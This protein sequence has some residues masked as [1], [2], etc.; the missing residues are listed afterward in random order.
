MIDLYS[1]PTFN[2]QKIHIALEE[3][4]LPYAAHPVNI[5]KGE[6]FDPAFLRISPNNRIPA[7]VDTDGAGGKSIS[8][9]ESG[10]IL[11]YLAEKTDQF[12]P[13]APDRRFET[14]QWLMWQMGGV[15]PMF[16]QAHHFLE[17]APEKI[18]YAKERYAKESN[19]LYG[20]L[21]R[22]LEGR[23]YVANDEYSIA[24]MALFPC[25]KAP[26]REGATLDD[27]PNVKRW[28]DQI[29]A[30]PAVQR[31]LG[32]MSEHRRQQSFSPGERENLF[33]KTQ[34]NRQ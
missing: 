13:S 24:D 31:G 19:R 27:Y 21:D 34:F 10:A 32:L 23:D 8:V 26:H 5:G 9:F 12:C 33:G 22:R 1:W 2:G 28:F 25:C 4:G 7:I 16:G 11:L 30:R 6:Q 17:Y 29:A 3:F 15:G 14:I 20:V 18:P